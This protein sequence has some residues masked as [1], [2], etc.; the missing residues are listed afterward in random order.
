MENIVSHPHFLVNHKNV[1]G[2]SAL[3]YAASFGASKYVFEVL[4]RYKADV[5][6][7]DERHRSVVG[8]YLRNPIS[9]DMQVVSLILRS[10]FDLYLLTK[11][12]LQQIFVVL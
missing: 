3:G 6:S 1:S 7:V 12:E 5:N 2:L 4:L 8:H 10:G 11:D 9:K